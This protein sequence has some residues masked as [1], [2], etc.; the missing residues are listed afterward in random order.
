VLKTEEK[1]SDVNLATH[2]LCDGFAGDY[3]VAVIISNDSDLVSPNLAVRAQ[4][5]LSVGVLL[6]KTKPSIQ[7][8]KAAK[9]KGLIDEDALKASQFPSLLTDANG[10]IAKPPTW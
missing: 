6:P 1:G 7:L 8:R 10:P 5:N 2:L 9:F 4:L 3:E